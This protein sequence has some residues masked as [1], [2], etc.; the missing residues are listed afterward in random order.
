MHDICR[1]PIPP[2]RKLL[3]PNRIIRRQSRITHRPTPL[4]IQRLELRRLRRAIKHESQIMKRGEAAPYNGNVLTSQL[5]QRPPDGVGL[6]WRLRGE[7]GELDNGDFGQRV[8]ELHWDEDAVIPCCVLYSQF[9]GGGGT[10][11]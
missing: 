5:A 1:R 10:V 7:D 9:F 2:R 4:L 6:L 11:V 8:D 3:F